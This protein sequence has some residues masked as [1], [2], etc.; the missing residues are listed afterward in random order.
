MKLVVVACLLA[1]LPVAAGA[2]TVH[3]EDF[4]ESGS[5][6]AFNGFESIPNDGTFFTGSFPYT[7]D[8]ISVEQVNGEGPAD[9]WVRCL[10]CF[11]GEIDGE[12]A[13][14]PSAGDQG[15]TRI[16]HPGGE[17]FVNIG[18]TTGLGFC[19]GQ[20]SI[21]FE[22][23]DDGVSV[24]TG[25]IR[26]IGS[27]PGYLGFSGGG[28][29]EIRVRSGQIGSP[30]PNVFALDSIEEGPATEP[31]TPVP[32]PGTMVLLGVGLAA[33]RLTRRRSIAPFTASRR[34]RS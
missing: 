27:A 3:I 11:G 6:T 13:W 2:I 9:I 4:I 23:L 31:G 29:D 8:G 17:A 24:L 26:G 33:S 15:Y 16:T 10:A 5:R 25:S 28:F 19:C 18:F 32:E 1:S 22:L 12:F 30:E 20:G 14:Y 34:A 7:E 21:G